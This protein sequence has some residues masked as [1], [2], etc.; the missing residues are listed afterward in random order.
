MAK[1]RS[2]KQ[3]NKPVVTAPEASYEVSS[4]SLTPKTSPLTD[5]RKPATK[6]PVAVFSEEA[7]EMVSHIIGLDRKDEVGWYMATTYN[8]ETNQVY[9]D[10]FWIP[11]QV[12]TPT[13]TEIDKISLALCKA[14]YVKSRNEGELFNAWFHLHPGSL[15]V[16]PSGTDEDMIADLIS[17]VRDNMDY[18][19]RGIVNSSGRVKIDFYS[20]KHG[21]VHEV[22]DYFIDKPQFEAMYNEIDL[23]LEQSVS[24]P[25][26][27]YITKGNLRHLP[28]TSDFQSLSSQIA[29]QS[30]ID[31]DTGYPLLAGLGDTLD[32]QVWD[33][34]EQ[35]NLTYHQDYKTL[36]WVND[37]MF[38]KHK[39]SNIEFFAEHN[40]HTDQIDIF[41]KSNR[42][43]ASFTSPITAS[44]EVE[45]WTSLMADV[46]YQ[47]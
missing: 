44:I 39:T 46:S 11:K 41:V 25:K 24:K 4:N 47:A 14:D 8:E 7:W 1:K 29:A 5:L 40:P 26:P 27:K 23:L 16:T 38:F 12:C 28:V 17:E 3:N 22:L 34:D 15:G 31:D 35:D 32:D 45:Y 37:R 10:K 6:P 2:N 42:N 19:V 20:M 43:R 18:Y 13:T 36:S 33:F 21:I 30:S 9:I